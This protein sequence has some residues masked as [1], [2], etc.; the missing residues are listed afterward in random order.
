MDGDV[1]A[2]VLEDLGREGLVGAFDLLQAGDIGRGR[3][4]PGLGRVDAR[5][6]AVDVPGGDLH[7]TGTYNQTGLRHARPC[8]G[9]PRLSLTASKNVDGRDKP[10]HD[11]GNH[12]ERELDR[13][14]GAAAAGRGDVRVVELELGADQ[15][16]DE[17]EL[18][19]LHEAERDGID[20]HARAVALDEEI[21]G[22]RL[23]D[24][25]EAVLEARAAAALDADAKQR[26]RRLAA[27]KLGDAAAPRAGLW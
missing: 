25:V 5:L 6:D 10:G 13:E 16:V 3:F 4:E 2:E 19:A 21:V 12:K 26:R 20:H 22:R 8:A 15:V 17:I 18:R 14:A 27:E 11:G 1:I 7:G 23:R 9:H 24:D